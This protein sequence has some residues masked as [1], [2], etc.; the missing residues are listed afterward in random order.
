M[1]KDYSEYSV[2]D[3][4]ADRF[5]EQW[6]NH[7]NA[8]TNQFWETWLA[9]H[10]Q[11]KPIVEEA[12]ELV[13]LMG[14]KT[15]VLEEHRVEDIFK[16]ITHTIQEEPFIK[17][18]KVN[19]H[20]SFIHNRLVKMAAVWI[21]IIMIAGFLLYT[22]KFNAT[23]IYTTGYRETKTITL[24]D[25]SVVT[26]NANSR[27][28]LADKWT[29][30]QNREVRLEGEAFFSVVHTANHQKFIVITSEDA[31]I[32]VLGTTFNV[33]NRRGNTRVVLSSGKVKLN[34]ESNN[35][36]KN[37][38]MQP[39]QLVEISDKEEIITNRIVQPEAYTAWQ[40]NILTFDDT[41]LWQ[42]AQTLEDNYGLKVDIQ[43]ST[44]LNRRYTGSTP[45]DKV[46][47]LLSKLSKIF[48]ARVTRNENSVM[49]KSN[50][51]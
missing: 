49:L 48:D 34:L 19:S 17:P 16:R 21:G 18:E 7:P 11:K 15:T 4:A 37:V 29:D 9:Q 32:E 35:Q 31:S 28:E 41:P 5:F 27:L 44:L 36:V 2:E 10:P 51:K 42:I 8:A 13:L 24:P 6:V 1:A 26:L 40:N 12:R 46:D 22:F 47:I 43:D 25:Q 38:I 20:R 50:E 45:A 3:F 30:T 39:G 23:I 33:N 14:F